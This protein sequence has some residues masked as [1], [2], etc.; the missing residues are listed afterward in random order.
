MEHEKLHQ[1]LIDQK[2]ELSQRIEQ[3][4]RDFK[5]RRADSRLHYGERDHSN[6]DVLMGLKNE[7]KMKLELTQDAIQRFIDDEFGYCIACGH[8]INDA[9]LTAL[10]HA[11]F[12]L[13]CAR[14]E[15]GNSTTVFSASNF[16]IKNDI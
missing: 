10:P 2:N 3:I 5:N 9:R 4:E 12:C 11:P 6:D 7:A 14:Q 15:G 8:P 13:A 1:L 16:L